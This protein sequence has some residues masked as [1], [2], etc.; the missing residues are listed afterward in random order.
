ML[1][2]SPSVGPWPR[3]TFFK[4][5]QSLLYH[6]LCQDFSIW[7]KKKKSPSPPKPCGLVSC[8]AG[9]LFPR[10]LFPSS[11]WPD[12]PRTNLWL[13]LNSQC[14]ISK[15][16]Q[17]P[18]KRER[19]RKRKK[20]LFPDL[21]ARS[22]WSPTLIPDRDVMRPWPWLWLFSRLEPWTVGSRPEFLSGPV[23]K[24]R[25][26]MDSF[27]APDPLCFLES[28]AAPGEGASRDL[29]DYIRLGWAPQSYG[30]SQSGPCHVQGCQQ[31][32]QPVPGQERVQNT[33]AWLEALKIITFPLFI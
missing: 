8:P 30:C 32:W 31:G 18:S 5:S 11:K 23:S 10:I 15:S 19:K 24:A 12:R 4:H 13:T 6:T 9:L 33:S 1:L 3:L 16:E 7:G 2:F 22:E 25:P 17:T 26:W 20:K 28:K 21:G 29:L 27:V 14:T